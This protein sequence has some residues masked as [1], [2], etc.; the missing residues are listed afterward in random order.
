MV[1]QEVCLKSYR[2]AASVKNTIPMA[3]RFCEDIE[4]GFI[5]DR[6][7]CETVLLLE[8]GSRIE[9]GSFLVLAERVILGLVRNGNSVD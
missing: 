2:S 8:V 3:R 4:R 6:G 9:V 7:G 1:C 5:K